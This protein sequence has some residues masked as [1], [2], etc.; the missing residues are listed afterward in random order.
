MQPFLK[1][2][3][4]KQDVLD[5]NITWLI[6]LRC[7]NIP[8]IEPLITNRGAQLKITCPKCQLENQ[9]DYYLIPEYLQLLSEKNNEI[10]NC[11]E[12]NHQMYKSVAY[13]YNCDKWLCTICRKT[14]NSL[15]PDHSISDD[16]IHIDISCQRHTSN[17]KIKY[18]CVEENLNLCQKCYTEHDTNHTIV[19]LSNFFTQKEANEAYK[20]FS[21]ILKEVNRINLNSLFYMLARIRAE[22]DDSY[23]PKVKNYIEINKQTSGPLQN[24][25]ELMFNNYFETVEKYPNFNIMNNLKKL[26]NFNTVP[27]EYDEEKN[28]ETNMQL[29]F[30][31]FEN[32]ASI[33]K[34]NCPLMIPKKKTNNLLKNLYDLGKSNISIGNMKTKDEE[35][36]INYGENL[37]ETYYK[38]FGDITA[39]CFQK[40][41]NILTGSNHQAI[42]DWNRKDL[43]KLDSYIDPIERINKIIQLKDRKIVAGTN[44]KKV[45]VYDEN[46]NLLKTI[47]DN[48]EILDVI[49]L[50]T[51]DIATLGSDNWV[52][53]YKNFEIDRL[54]PLDMK[55][56]KIIQINHKNEL[57]IILEN[58]N[59]YY[60]RVLTFDSLECIEEFSEH[61]DKII[62]VVELEDGRVLS[63]SLDGTVVLYNVIDLKVDCKFNLKDT[64]TLTSLGDL[65]AITNGSKK[66]NYLIKNISELGKND[67]LIGNW[68]TK[69]Q[70]LDVNYGNDLVN[71]ICKDFGE[72]STL[73]FQK[74][75]NILTG[76]N[77]QAIDDWDI[78]TL[79]K[80]NSY[81]DPTEKI[82]KIIQ[83]SDNKILVATLEKKIFIYDEEKKLLNTIEDN[84]EILDMV[85]LTDGNFATINN[86]NLVKFYKNFEIDRLLPVELPPTRLLQCHKRDYI[87]VALDSD[88]K[89]IIRIVK[90]D[91]LE[92]VD[93][94]FDHEQKI[95][96]IAELL[97]GRIISTSIDDTIIIY[98]IKNLCIE[99]KFKINEKSLI[100]EEIGDINIYTPGLPEYNYLVQNLYCLSVNNISLGFYK[101]NVNKYNINT[102]SDFLEILKNDF[103]NITAI[104][105]KKNG[106]LLIGNENKEVDEWDL[107]TCE[108]LNSYNDSNDKIV[109]IIEIENEKI[110]VANKDKKLLVYDEEKK[111]SETIETDSEIIDVI[112]LKNGTLVTI[113]SD[114]TVK[115]YIDFKFD[116]QISLEGKPSKLLQSHI[117]ENLL[118]VTFNCKNK[119]II[120]VIN[121]ETQETEIDLADH[122]DTI[123]NMVEI[124]DGNIM[125]ISIDGLVV[126][127]NIEDCKPICKF[128]CLEDLD[129]LREK[130]DLCLYDED[131]KPAPTEDE[132]T[133]EENEEEILPAEVS[134]QI[135]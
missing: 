15:N 130:K 37:C 1:K 34:L 24:I 85:E 32:N 87:I 108:K 135:K 106:N 60:V 4:P 75:G 13:C 84:A 111:L 29:F 101:K 65:R 41:G 17:N 131:E 30:D 42:D 112:Q 73:C 26:C 117:K 114:N 77:H 74:N 97:D 89:H 36:D 39:I 45:F 72:I 51:G 133:E 53:F 129:I 8:S 48:A 47:E 25:I 120:R 33:T 14:H 7:K 126:I 61:K 27:F 68:F 76:S 88:N 102:S 123:I 18:Y 5:K 21:K 99:Y 19:D 71:T 40:N 110:V 9:P 134:E 44:D 70:S 2:I 82:T 96:N 57:V 64:K 78:N 52:K 104:C 109:K 43:K 95:T 10:I 105:L 121:I 31:Y 122:D 98:D 35:F 56:L 132:K 11:S 83:T 128:N 124:N 38:D 23:I 22:G 92:T 63:I 54:L 86:D 20:N 55:L 115:F 12:P 118:F 46:K 16:D 91:V 59:K 127:F 3:Q 90:K 28:F 67:I 93:E 107:N 62:N 100:A 94:Y 58:E 113:N 79:E 66:P 119:H 69:N 50:C 6:C 80:I 125:T 49:E 116:K 81:I 103:G